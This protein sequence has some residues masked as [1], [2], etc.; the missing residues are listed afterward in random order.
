M[1]EHANQD[2]GWGRRRRRT[3]LVTSSFYRSSRVKSSIQTWSN[4]RTSL[5]TITG[6]RSWSKPGLTYDQWP[7]KRQTESIIPKKTQS[8]I[9]TSLSKTSQF[10]KW[11]SHLGAKETRMSTKWITRMTQRCKPFPQ[12]MRWSCNPGSLHLSHLTAAR[13]AHTRNGRRAER[14]FRSTTRRSLL[15]LLWD[16]E[17]TSST[18]GKRSPTVDT[19]EI[20]A[21]KKSSLTFKDSTRAQILGTGR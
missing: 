17:I 10:S 1:T 4:W 9:R 18:K 21:N 13:A 8:S 7:G 15:S 3:Y 11:C 20:Q 12:P 19:P 16:K 14:F 6:Q 2:K 5:R